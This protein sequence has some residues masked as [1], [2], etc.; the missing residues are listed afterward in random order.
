MQSGG[1]DASTDATRPG[2]R[3]SVDAQVRSGYTCNLAV[4]RN[5]E[6]KM[7]NEL[8]QVKLRGDIWILIL[9]EIRCILEIASQSWTRCVLD[10]TQSSGCAQSQSGRDAILDASAI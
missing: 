1:H 5:P 9:N 2:L 6:H 10:A 4:A 8:I 7:F 3:A